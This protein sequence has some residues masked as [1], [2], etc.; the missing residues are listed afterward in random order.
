VESVDEIVHTFARNIFAIAFVL[1]AEST[2]MR[3]QDQTVQ[4]LQIFD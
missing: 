4:L 2:A 3:A 1:F